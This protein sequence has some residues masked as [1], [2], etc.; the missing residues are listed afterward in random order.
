MYAVD[1]R[2]Q[3]ERLRGSLKEEGGQRES[4]CAT[5]NPQ[6]GMRKRRT[7]YPTDLG[8][9]RLQVPPLLQAAFIFPLE[10]PLVFCCLHIA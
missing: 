3:D 5:D 8:E 2:Q 6:C 9:L 7:G 4:R 10:L 1:S